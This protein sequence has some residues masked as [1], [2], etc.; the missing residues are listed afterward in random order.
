MVRFWRKES[1]IAGLVTLLVLCGFI[2]VG[3]AET[4]VTGKVEL[5]KSR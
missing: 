4:D 3:Y 1:L 5:I 2:S